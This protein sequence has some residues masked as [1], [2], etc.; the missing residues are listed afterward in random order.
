MDNQY[1]IQWDKLDEER[2]EERQYYIVEIDN[3]HRLERLYNAPKDDFN[4]NIA[5]SNLHKTFSELPRYRFPLK[6]DPNGVPFPENGIYLFFEESE[7]WGNMD[8]IVK[9][10][11]HKKDGRLLKRLKKHIDNHISASSFRK[12]LGEALV[13]ANSSTILN[14]EDEITKHLTEKM[15]FCVF[16]VETKEEREF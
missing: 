9:V 12:Y 3:T 16:E 10:G 14:I 6:E 13:N 5:S 1:Q 15:S 11:T 8:R 7:K 2:Q 4:E